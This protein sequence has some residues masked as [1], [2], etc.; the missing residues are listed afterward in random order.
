MNKPFPTS[1]LS[2][3]LVFIGTSVFVGSSAIAAVAIDQQ[4]IFATK[5]VPA[6]I[7]LIGSFEFPTMV[8]RA[9]KGGTQSS[10]IEVIPDESESGNLKDEEDPGFRTESVTENENQYYETSSYIGYFDNKKCYQYH[11]EDAEEKRHFFPV[12]TNGP[13]CPGAADWS[14]N[15]LNWATMQTIDIYRH[16][17]TGGHRSTDTE[18]ETILEKGWQ[19]GQGNTNNFPL[20]NIYIKN[21]GEIANATAAA[22]GNLSWSR[23]RTRLGQEKIRSNYIAF[24]NTLRFGN[25][26]SLQNNLINAKPP[27]QLNPYKGGALDGKTMSSK[28]SGYTT[29]EVSVRVKVCDPRFPEANCVKQKSGHYKPVGLIQQYAEQQGIPRLRFSAFD[30]LND[31]SDA[32]TYGKNR[33]RKGGV[34]RSRMKYVGPHSA[35]DNNIAQTNPTAEWDERTGVFTKNPAPSDQQ[36]TDTAIDSGIIAYIN[37]SGSIV[38]GTKYKRHDN[39]SE[40]YYT[41][42]RYLKGLDNIPEYTNLSVNKSG[43]STAQLVGG[44]LVI[45]NWKKDDHDPI[46]FSCQKNFFLGIGDTLTASDRG[47]VEDAKDDPLFDG[48]FKA[49]RR[50]MHARENIKDTYA[51]NDRGSDYLAVLAYDANTADLRPDMPG[52]QTASTYWLDI[53][54]KGLKPKDE[55]PYWM[56]AKY[57]GFKVPSVFKPTQ[58]NAPIKD[59]LWWTSNELLNTRDKNKQNKRPDN[60]YVVN[61]P[62]SMIEGLNRAF[63]SIQLDQ[64][65]A[66]SS[67]AIS[68]AQTDDELMAYQTRYVSGSWTGNLYG[69]EFD[70]KTKA[71]K[72]AP[73]WDAESQL[74]NWKDRNVYTNISG[75]KK[76]ISNGTNFADLTQDQVNY[77]LGDRSKEGSEFRQRDAVLGD[78]I[79]SQPV[80][81]GR[82]Q[83]DAFSTRNFPEQESYSKWA[84][85]HAD[86]K[87][88][89][90]VGGNDG[91]LHGFDAK[92]GKETFAFIPATVIE[93]GLKRLTDKDYLHRY[94]VDGKITVADTYINGS[95]RTILV[96]TLGA[97]GVSDDR[98]STHNAIFALNITDPENI[99]LLWEK[100]SD[101]IPELGINLGQPV[102][103]QNEKEQWKVVL[104]NGPNSQKDT[105]SLISLDLTGN[106]QAYELSSV[107]NNGLS[108]LRTWDSTG[109]GLTD[110]L[111]GGDLQGNVWKIS[112]LTGPPKITKLFTAVDTDGLVQPITTTPLVGVSPYD[113]TT[114][115]FFGTGQYLSTADVVNDQL[116]TWYG[117][118]DNGVKALKRS[119]LRERLIEAEI[120]NQKTAVIER[121]IE[122]GTLAEMVGKQG[123]FIDLYRIVDDK[124]EK[125]GER[126]VIENQF[127][128]RTLIGV[129]RVPNANDPCAPFGSGM[130]MAINPFTGARLDSSFFD[131]NQ[132]G[133]VSNKDLVTIDGKKVPV[134]GVSIQT[135]SS[136]PTFLGNKMLSSDTQGP[137][138]STVNIDRSIL[139][140]PS[141]R[142]LI[143]REN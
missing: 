72:A 143:N 130:I 64:S 103:I 83:V 97:G 22:P 131:I 137:T 84:A 68:S 90:Y 78:I 135:G 26:Y 27:I 92:T 47:F 94:S 120:T 42:Y 34:M 51:D 59:E 55:N 60:F 28:K 61:D 57:G 107:T 82:P 113:R 117:I 91:M 54:E 126:M 141:W 99:S 35:D 6:N 25:T 69:Y 1:L 138:N 124:K 95:W 30:Y 63:Q 33:N 50:N 142:E 70:T 38:E 41:A 106:T 79:N 96:G 24:G 19:T 18:S 9:Y 100:T 62:E 129:T 87:P 112:N 56:A 85:S 48:T 109:D 21:R 88:T 77:L 20:G 10:I 45:S 71:P 102:I 122:K 108:S 132:D 80:Y 123:W 125:Y 76:F 101:D 93:N 31:P 36:D 74:P 86:R 81:V 23:F 13:L 98:Q 15:F 52:I 46:Q 136:M 12:N 75:L 140:Q 58:S 116:Q 115:L 2:K 40:L 43:V 121:I 32:N 119:D 73:E 49:L 44:L 53:L 14:G 127:Q 16:A 39:V 133:L 67:I 3:A 105:A 128:G 8:S 111:Y 114:W 5:P 134:S 66:D 7:T 29:Y 118:K 139:L 104:G 4:P 65:G 89:V 37:R 17:L 110:T 11:Y